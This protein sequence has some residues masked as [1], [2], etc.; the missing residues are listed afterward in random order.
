MATHSPADGY[1]FKA[2]SCLLVCSL[3][4][5]LLGYTICGQHSTLSRQ[6]LGYS[7]ND[8]GSYT[9]LGQ[10]LVCFFGGQL[11]GST[12]GGG[13]SATRWED[14][15]GYS[16]GAAD[17]SFEATARLLVWRRTT[18]PLVLCTS[19]R[20]LFRQMSD[21]VLVGCSSSYTSSGQRLISARSAMAAWLHV[22]W[23]T[24][25]LAQGMR[26]TIG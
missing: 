13:K 6:L 21:Q 24:N 19:D 22:R 14:V 3:G 8:G 10:R 2:A 18:W 1:S 15:I 9:Q 23:S 5:W 16:F 20:L 7:V 4:G 11:L 26:A 17:H 12:F 25:R